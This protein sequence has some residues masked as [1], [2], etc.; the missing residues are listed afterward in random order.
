MVRQPIMMASFISYEWESWLWLTILGA[1]KVNHFFSWIELNFHPFSSS[2]PPSSFFPS[3]KSGV[4]SY[5]SLILG[6]GPSPQ[7]IKGPLNYIIHFIK[8]SGSPTNMHQNYPKRLLKHILLGSIHNF[9]FSRF[10]IIVLGQT[11]CI[12]SKF[13]NDGDAA[14]P[15]PTLWEPLA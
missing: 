3:Y 12:S 4:T 9:W 2:F 7:A 1:I 14:I 10:S 5:Y 8:N 11:I 13:S 15:G 6:S